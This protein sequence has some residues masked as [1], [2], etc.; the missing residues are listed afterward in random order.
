MR[1]GLMIKKKWLM[2]IALCLY[3]SAALAAD[4][5]R[6]VPVSFASLATTYAP[7]T[8]G[9]G[10]WLAVTGATANSFPCT[11][12]SAVVMAYTDGVQWNCYA[13]AAGLTT[14]NHL[15][16]L[17]AATGNYSMNSHKL[18]GLVAGTTSGDTMAYGLNTLDQLTTATGNYAMGTHKLTGL[19]AGSGSGDSLAYGLNSLDQLAT[20]AGNYAMGTHKL[21]GLSAGTTSGDSMAYGL[22]TL[23]QLTTAGGNYNMGGHI[24]TNLGGAFFRSMLSASTLSS[25][26]APTSGGPYFMVWN[27]ANSTNFLSSETSAHIQIPFAATVKN[28]Y[29]ISNTTQGAGVG[30]TFL[31]EINGA[32]SSP[33]LTCSIVNA[34]TCSDTSDAPTL[35]AGQTSSLKVTLT[36][37][38]TTSKV[39]CAVELDS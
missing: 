37:T 11:S 2:L 23:D 31:V 36:G 15:N 10:T 21:T 8:V 27:G 7:G 32:D 25:V 39:S 13:N 4:A 14:A 33:A 1:T 16:D 38:P 6:F 19:A 24:L 5:I 20:S 29:C 9:S 17:T 22:N 26:N 30:Y 3:A 28:L 12:G 35:T 18:T 34:A